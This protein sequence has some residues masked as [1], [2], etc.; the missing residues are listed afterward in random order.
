M[1]AIKN[2]LAPYEGQF[3]TQT[4][5]QMVAQMLCECRKTMGYQQKEVA[6]I[7][8]ISP[9]TYNGYEKGRNEPPIE[10]LVRLSFLYDLPVDILV[11]RNRFHSD[12]QSAIVSIK[13]AE[14]E[15]ADVREW[16]SSD[17]LGQ[18]EQIQ[19]LINAMELLTDA[20]RQ[21]V[22]KEERK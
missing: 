20:S 2:P 21:L 1:E 22:E 4:R 11:Q 15:L 8:G 10:I 9:Q 14:A 5:K 12:D 16:L 3:D 19:A 17:P 18:N 13:K 7:L 6:E